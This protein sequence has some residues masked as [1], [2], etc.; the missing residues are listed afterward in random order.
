MIAT[1]QGIQPFNEPF[2]MQIVSPQI[3][4]YFRDHEV[5]G[6]TIRVHAF[7]YIIVTC[8]CCCLVKVLYSIV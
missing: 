3:I 4:P 1:I 2:C 6:R 7:F 5:R 8:R